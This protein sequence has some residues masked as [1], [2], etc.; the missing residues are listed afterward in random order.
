MTIEETT[1]LDFGAVDDLAFAAERGRL[2]VAAL[3][4]MFVADQLGPLVE[5]SHLTRAGRLPPDLA[6]KGVDWSSHRELGLAFKSGAKR[7]RAG[8]N[9]GLL[10]TSTSGDESDW[11]AFAIEAKRAALG[12]GLSN[13]WASQMVG[14]LGELRSNIVEHS[15]AAESGLVVFSGLPGRFEFV[16]SDSGVGLLATLREAVEYRALSD[17]GEAL[18]LALTEGTS[19]YGRHQ[20][21]GYGFKPLFTGLA[22]RKASLRFR[23]GNASLVVNGTTPALVRSQTGLKSWI[24]GFFVSVSCQVSPRGSPTN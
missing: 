12:A 8:T 17:H 23:T 1:Q 11:I 18:R 5:L 13:D 16:A 7:C 6:A 19:R 22:N 21:R 14:A 15:N 24:D 20:G 10:R 4:D 2:D 9:A 3:R